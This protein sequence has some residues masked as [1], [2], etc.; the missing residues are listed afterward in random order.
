MKIL[1]ATS[2]AVPFAKTGGLA[3]V[4]AHCRSSWKAR[5]R[6][7]CDPAGLPAARSC[8]LPIEPTGVHFDVPIG[9]K[10]VAGQLSQEPIARQLRCRS[11]WSSRTSTTTATDLYQEDGTDYKD[12]CERFVF[13]CRAVLEA[14]RLLDLQRR[15]AARQRLA[16]RAG[17]GLSEDRISRRARLRADRHAVHDPQ[18]GLPG[19]CSGTG[20][21]C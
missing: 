21:C 3:D 20:T 18:H 1:M 9:S 7:V 19:R 16:D 5:A 17:A 12:N 13:F 8:G 11:I 6:S 14:I 10:T 15:R 2:E 4:S